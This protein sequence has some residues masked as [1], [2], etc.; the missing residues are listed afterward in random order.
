[1]VLV[2]LAQAGLGYAAIRT[3]SPWFWLAG[4]PIAYLLIGGLGAYSTTGGLPAARARDRGALL[5]V[6]GGAS[7]AVVAT[8]VMAAILVVLFNQANH[9]LRPSPDS[10][11]WYGSSWYASGWYGNGPGLG[12]FGLGLLLL[13]VPAFVGLNLL[14]IGLSTVGGLVGGTLRAS[15]RRAGGERLV[16][17][18]LAGPAGQDRRTGTSRRWIAVVAVAATLAVLVVVAGLVLTTG[19]FPAIH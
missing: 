1:M 4:T 7:G 17:E 12:L 3:S 14:G 9:A 2:P 10:N 5:G 13:F 18:S 16:Q 15:G 11:Y 6:I 19:A 8:L